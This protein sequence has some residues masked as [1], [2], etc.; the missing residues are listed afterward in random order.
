MGEPNDLGLPWHSK[1]TAVLSLGLDAG[2][3]SE[4]GGKV[5]MRLATLLSLGLNRWHEDEGG[6]DGGWHSRWAKT[7]RRTRN[8]EAEDVVVQS[9]RQHEIWKWS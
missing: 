6:E 9:P 1:K 5:G 8:Q 3:I 2:E 4:V 7:S